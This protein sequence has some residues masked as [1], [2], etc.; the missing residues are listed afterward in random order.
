MHHARTDLARRARHGFRA[1]GLNRIEGLRAALGQNPDK[2][3]DHACAAR[4]RLHRGR[5]AQVRLD[6]VNL[7]DPAQRLQVTG[8][9]RPPDP[10]PDAIVPLG[11]RP[12]HVPAEKTRS[13]EDRDKRIDAG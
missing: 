10:D 2:V 7:A 4:R 11:E 3:D 12:D 5:I 9:F 1:L 8:Q 6:R 13:S